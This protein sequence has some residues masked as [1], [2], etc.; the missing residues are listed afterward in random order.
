[1]CTFIFLHSNYVF[2]SH[3]WMKYLLVDV[4]HLQGLFSSF[5]FFYLYQFYVFLSLAFHDWAGFPDDVLSNIFI[6]AETVALLQSAQFVCR[7]W[8]EVSKKPQIF[9]QVT[10]RVYCSSHLECSR[11]LVKIAKNAIDQS[12]GYL[13]EF[14]LV[15]IF[16]LFKSIWNWFKRGH[17]V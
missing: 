8:Q 15:D 11:K 17:L 1:M 16:V 5:L 7:K 13:E 10:I 14:S 3:R 6:K 9:W 4:F 12:D 2:Y